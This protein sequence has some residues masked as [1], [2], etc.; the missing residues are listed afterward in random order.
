MLKSNFFLKMLGVLL[1]RVILTF[2]DF[3]L[4]MHRSLTQYSISE[5]RC[6]TGH[7]NNDIGCKARSSGEKNAG[8]YHNFEGGQGHLG[9]L[10]SFSIGCMLCEFSVEMNSYEKVLHMWL[11]CFSLF[12]SMWQ[13]K[14]IERLKKVDRKVPSLRYI[15][16]LCDVCQVQPF[17][18]LT[19]ILANLS[20]GQCYH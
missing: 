5:K 9:P 13:D 1:K 19:F 16:G 7:L 4:T 14:L 15:Y 17:I 11:V 12:V 8:L 2:R 20:P 3:F 18:Y 10:H 6:W